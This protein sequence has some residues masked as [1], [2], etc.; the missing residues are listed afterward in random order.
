MQLIDSFKNIFKIKDLRD[1]IF[2]TLLLVIVFRLGTHIPFPGIDAEA[3]LSFAKRQSE[4]LGQ[5]WGFL[6]VFSGGAF[7]NLGI[8]TLGIMPYITASIIMSLLTK[9]YPALEEIAKEGTT[10]QRKIAQYTRLLTVPIAVVQA[11]LTYTWVKTSG[12]GIFVNSGIISY[13]MCVF[14]LVTGTLFV[15]WLGEQISEHGVGNGASILVAVGILDRMPALAGQFSSAVKSDPDVINKIIALLVLWFLMIVAVVLITQSQRKIPVQNPKHFR[16]RR[17]MMA[18]RNYLPLSINAGGVMPV[19]FA[20]SLL[21]VPYLL[22][23]IPGFAPIKNL[24]QPGQFFYLFFYIVL[25]FF[26]SFFWTYLMYKP[27]EMANNLKEYGS[28]IPGIRPGD[29]TSH[30]INYILARITMF[31]AAFL[32]FIVLVP[33]VVSAAM[34][35]TRYQVSFLGGTGI[36]IIV[37]VTLDVLRKVESHLLLHH[38]SGFAG[39]TPIR[40]RR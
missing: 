40:G 12:A 16:G 6:Q 27:D 24:F 21:S 3:V 4:G 32:C 39:S 31:G 8:F 9:V 29:N 34:G 30:Y 18:Q 11:S 22:A 2:V 1:R 13:L 17:I 26:F 15:M 35:M 33:D 38:Y 28:F 7:E 20:S 14:A 10:G 25:V 37:G 36:L 23:N 5:F 19:I